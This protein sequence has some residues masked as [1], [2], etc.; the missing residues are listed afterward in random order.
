MQKEL[1]TLGKSLAVIV[2]GV[3][4][5]NYVQTTWLS[6]STIAPSTKA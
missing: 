3:L 4:I 2:A 5:A 6:K 1:V